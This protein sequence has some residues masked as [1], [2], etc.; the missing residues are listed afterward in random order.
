[1]NLRTPRLPLKKSR[2]RLFAR[3]EDRATVLGEL[4]TRVEESDDERL[5]TPH[6]DTI[7]PRLTSSG[8]ERPV[9]VYLYTPTHSHRAIMYSVGSFKRVGRANVEVE[10]LPQTRLSSY[11]LRLRRQSKGERERASCTSL[12]GLNFPATFPGSWPVWLLPFAS[13][14]DSRGI[15]I[16]FL[17]T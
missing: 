12:G 10:R 9:Y 3:S 5:D 2:E 6:E 1:M 16:S 14:P 17:A 4:V 11:S 13:L 15:L 8:I 7:Y